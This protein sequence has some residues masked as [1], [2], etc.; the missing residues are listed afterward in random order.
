MKKANKGPYAFPHI[1]I[2]DASINGELCELVADDILRGGDE[3]LPLREL[4]QT[5]ADLIR[6]FILSPS[7]SSSGN[8]PADLAS[9]KAIYNDGPILQTILILQGLLCYGMMIHALRMCWRVQYGVRLSGIPK[10][11]VPFRAKDVLVERAEFGHPDLAIMLG[12]SHSLYSY[13]DYGANL[14]FCMLISN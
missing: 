6:S 11:A 1:R 14:H 8:V 2:L 4:R 13:H 5:D 3:N 10:M 7:A 9:I 12:I